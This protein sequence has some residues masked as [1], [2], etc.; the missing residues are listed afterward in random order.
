MKRGD[1]Y[2]YETGELIRKGT[3]E[4]EHGDITGGKLLLYILGGFAK[5]L[6]IVFLG[7]GAFIYYAFKALMR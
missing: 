4:V 7:V 2:D 6:G 5:V 1:V 3:G